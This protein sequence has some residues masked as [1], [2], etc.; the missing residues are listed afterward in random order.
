MHWRE[1]KKGVR[2]RQ[3]TSDGEQAG[4]RAE[5]S[6]ANFGVHPCTNQQVAT[7]VATAM[8]TL[9]LAHGTGRHDSMRIHAGRMTTSGAEGSKGGQWRACT[10]VP[11]SSRRRRVGI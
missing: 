9:A 2:K 1:L 10:G 7:H 6:A 5:H 8:T 3:F 11:V 4:S